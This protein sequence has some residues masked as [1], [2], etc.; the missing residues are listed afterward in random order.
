MNNCI[1]VPLYTNS[2]M[3]LTFIL[4]LDY[5][6][7]NDITK[8]VSAN[9]AKM[10]KFREKQNRPLLKLQEKMEIIVKYS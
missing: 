7:R 4:I 3:E 8:F 5:I 10:Q 9:K 2:R 1:S 6:F